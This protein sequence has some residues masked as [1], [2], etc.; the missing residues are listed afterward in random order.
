MAFSFIERLISNNSREKPLIITPR[1]VL[2]LPELNMAQAFV[3][4]YLKNKAYLAPWEVEKDE[5]FYTLAHFNTMISQ[6]HYLFEQDAAVR[7]VIMDKT[8]SSVIGICNF[9]SI[10]RGIAQSCYLGYA[11]DEAFQGQ[12]YMKEALTSGL[13]YMFEQ[14]QI[15]RI[16]ANYMPHNH[17]SA[18]LLNSL[19]FVKEGYAKSCFKVAGKWQDHI[20][21]AKIQPTD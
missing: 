4:Y 19:G 8:Q 13:D 10:I 21:T 1:T 17:N 16:M 20:L 2:C 12:G 3:N 5:H 15:H 9:T 7:F 6:V 14:W 18:A 11:I